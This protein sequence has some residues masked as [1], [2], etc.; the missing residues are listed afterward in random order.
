MH[1]IARQLRYI[2]AAAREGS[3]SA[4]AETESI[5]PSSILLAIDKFEA[6]YKTQLFVRLKSKGLRLTADGRA[7]INRINNFIIEFGALERDL[8]RASAQLDGDLRVGMLS[9]ASAIFGP[10][11]LKAL[12]SSHPDLTIHITEGSSVDVREQLR[13]GCV[14]VALAYDVY[15]EDGIDVTPLLE[16]PPY[17]ALAASDPLACEDRVSIQAIA[18][19]PVIVVNKPDMMRYS[20]SFFERHA[21]RPSGLYETLSF[22]AARSAA[23]LG[24]GLGFLHLRPLVDMTYSGE[25]IVC[26]PIAETSVPPTLSILTRS[27]SRLSRRAQVFVD[28]CAEFFLSEDAKA[29][30]VS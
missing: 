24:L 16:A 25:P 12:S 20:T 13:T 14:D 22:E 8:E 1:D 10:L 15:V 28:H 5:S 19:R 3:I 2:A 17:L 4:A 29:Y 6:R 27:G 9:T 7:M 30:A 26:R 11:I 21:V 23:A 18:G